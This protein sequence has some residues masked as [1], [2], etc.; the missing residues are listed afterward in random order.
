MK[1]DYDRVDRLATTATD[2]IGKILIIL[3]SKDKDKE[4]CDKIRKLIMELKT[5][6]K[7]DNK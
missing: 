3:D 5:P 4:K 6:Q 7:S 2:A 1:S